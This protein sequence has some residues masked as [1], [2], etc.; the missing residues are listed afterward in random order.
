[1]TIVR[2]FVMFVKESA[3]KV[4]KTTPVVWTQASTYGL[5]N[6]DAYYGRLPGSNQFTMRMRP[7]GLVT[8]PYGGGIDIPAFTVSDKQECVGRYTSIASVST[9]PFFLSWAGVRINAGQTSPWVTT[10]IPGDLASASIYHGIQLSDG[11]IL[12]KV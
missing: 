7:I 11:T 5:A 4:P 12:R 6:S 8:V 10:E 9:L 3:Y 2:E 1:M